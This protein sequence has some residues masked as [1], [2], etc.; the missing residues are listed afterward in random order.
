MNI[1]VQGKDIEIDRPRLQ[2]WIQQVKLQKEII[3]IVEKHDPDDVSKAIYQYLNFF[4]EQD[5]EKISWL[6]VLLALAQ[7]TNLCV[8]K[9]DFPIFHTKE[10]TEQVIADYS[11]K[12]W[13]FWLNFMCEKYHWL[14]EYVQ[15]LQIEDAFGLLQEGL[16]DEQQQ[17]EWQWSLTELAY[18]YNADTKTSSFKPLT[19]PDWMTILK[20]NMPKKMRMRKDMLPQ[21]NVIDFGEL[22]AHAE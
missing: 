2:R 1:S 13:Y 16:I 5:W 22:Y 3:T 11:E 4:T 17:R 9:I 15:E 6:E 8:P 19:R 12:E 18:P 10:K 14:I 20:D 7:I 21:G